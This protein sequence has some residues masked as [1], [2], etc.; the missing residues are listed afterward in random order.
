MSRRKYPRQLSKSRPRRRRHVRRDD[1]R[2]HKI[3]WPGF[4][5]FISWQAHHP[6]SNSGINLSRLGTAS[7]LCRLASTIGSC[8]GG[9]CLTGAAELGVNVAGPSFPVCPLVATMISLFQSNFAKSL[10]KRDYRGFVSPTSGS[11]LSHCGSLLLTGSRPEYPGRA[12]KARLWHR[13]MRPGRLGGAS[14]QYQASKSCLGDFL[15]SLLYLRCSRLP[16]CYILHC[17]S[18]ARPLRHPTAF[19]TT[20]AFY[21]SDS[22][23]P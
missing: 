17:L 22:G 16:V 15:G 20:R 8:I 18:R 7:R 13:C 10:K 14:R 12:P 19:L 23:P 1:A 9:G 5:L 4:C 11:F 21:C 3:F 6:R 2:R